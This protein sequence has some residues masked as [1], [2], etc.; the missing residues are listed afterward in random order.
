MC[1]HTSLAIRSNATMFPAGSWIHRRSG[2]GSHL[3]KKMYG[4]GCVRA[5]S[6]S[7]FETPSPPMLLLQSG[8]TAVP[9]RSG[10]C[11]LHVYMMRHCIASGI[12]HARS[13]MV[14]KQDKPRHEKAPEESPLRLAWLASALPL[15]NASPA[16]IVQSLYIFPAT[17]SRPPSRT[18]ARTP[19]HIAPPPPQSSKAHHSPCSRAHL[20]SIP[21]HLANVPQIV[22]PEQF[23][24]PLPARLCEWAPLT[25][26]VHPEWRDA[27]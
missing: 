18:P 1:A 22:L 10:L 23:Q 9:A 7:G 16:L 25:V 6:P 19:A 4:W 11:L 27:D 3:A 15:L 26:A 21:R 13:V 24:Q 14:L 8:C 20:H 2:R 17:P 12:G 5:L